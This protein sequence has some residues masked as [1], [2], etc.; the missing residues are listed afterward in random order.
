M[1]AVV[2]GVRERAGL[3][4]QSQHVH[5]GVYAEA[6][7]WGVCRVV[8][9][10]YHDDTVAS[11]FFPIVRYLL[12]CAGIATKHFADLAAWWTCAKSGVSS[13]SRCQCAS[14]ATTQRLSSYYLGCD[15]STAVRR[16]LAATFHELLFCDASTSSKSKAVV[17]SALAEDVRLWAELAEAFAY[18]LSARRP[19]MDRALIRRAVSRAQELGLS[20]WEA[21]CSLQVCR[22]PKEHNYIELSQCDRCVVVT[23]VYRL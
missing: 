23:I 18:S 1:A 13:T 17:S 7:R 22:S 8:R 2:R 9:K 14:T 3:G 4:C 19:K 20:H 10:S 21:T 15:G 12:R 5:V 11:S 6:V 16:C